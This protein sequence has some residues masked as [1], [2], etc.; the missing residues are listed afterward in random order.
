[1]KIPFL[2]YQVLHEAELKE[3]VLANKGN[4]NIAKKVT[5]HGL[6]VC[7]KGK[8]V[9]LRDRLVLLFSSMSVKL[10]T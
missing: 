4:E 1:M 2:A 10:Q 5:D 7:E 8:E 3:N 6:I 9:W